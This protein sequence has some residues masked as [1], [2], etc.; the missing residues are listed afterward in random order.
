MVSCATLRSHMRKFPAPAS[1]FTN[2][3]SFRAGRERVLAAC[4]G[5]S[6]RGISAPAIGPG[7]AFYLI[8]HGA[9]CYWTRLKWLADLVPI[10][11]K[12]PDANKS[13]II[14]RA[15]VV[16]ATSSLAASLILLNTLFPF[17]ALGPLRSWLEGVRDNPPVRKRL[18]AYVRAISTPGFDGTSPLDDRWATL[19]P[20][21]SFFEAPSM[22]AQ[23]LVFGPISSA[24]RAT[25]TSIARQD[26]RKSS[27][28]NSP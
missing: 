21:W 6:V 18:A 14:E 20:T 12:L 4:P 26:A 13:D 22:R 1:S 7:L 11:A 28:D 16:R 10:F 24:L 27:R 3:R 17:V 9:I 2:A 15:H 25:A 19:R 8:A 23:L 5:I